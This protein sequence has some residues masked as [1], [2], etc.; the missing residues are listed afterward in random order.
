[1]KY[2]FTITKK[3][4]EN[5]LTVILI[6]KPE[7]VKSFFM[8]SAPVGGAD[9]VQSVNGKRV[10]RRSGLA[11]YMEHQMFRYNGQDV[12]ELFARMQC[13]CNAFTTYID[14][15]YYFQTTADI[16]KPLQ[17]LLSFVENLDIT[18]ESVEKERGIILSEYDM[19]EQAP[20]QRLLKE[21]WKS[22]YLN[23]PMRIDVLGTPED[24][25]QISVEDLSEF[26]KQNYDPS[27]LLLIGITGKETEPIMEWLEENQK[28]VGS[29]GDNGIERIVEEEP[30]EV[31]RQEYSESMDITIPYVSV[32][33]KLKTE[34]DPLTALK[35]DT[36]LQMYL[37]SLFGVKNPDYQTWLN[38]R[39]FN[40]ILG[41]ECDISPDHA[42]VLI[43]AQTAKQE[44]FIKIA[45]ETIKKLQSEPMDKEVFEALKAKQFA[46]VVRT[47]D[48]FEPFAIDLMHSYFEKYDY[49]Q[50]IEDLSSLTAESAWEDVR[51]I[52][53]SNRAVVQIVPKSSVSSKTEENR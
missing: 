7:Y 16:Y 41:A 8:L 42:Y 10:V 27:R 28:S 2:N 32:T 47:L 13:T 20:D 5:G 30:A 48:R 21:T 22:L 51:D 36:S 3:K 31:V 4:L 44:E 29:I 52:D 24:I 45:D 15:S 23:H 11:H 1:M 34:K 25:S 18:E 53:F 46:T 12:S 40:G 38:K 37:D 33:Y 26:Y 35:K 17:L 19:Y 39:I 6:H 14:T 9:I 43:Y 50:S 49:F